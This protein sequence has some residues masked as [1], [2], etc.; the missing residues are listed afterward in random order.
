VRLALIALSHPGVLR[1]IGIAALGY[2][3]GQFAHPLAVA[4]GWGR[5]HRD[6][7]PRS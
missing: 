6:R 5:T 4:L 1:V 7:G 2:A 3:V